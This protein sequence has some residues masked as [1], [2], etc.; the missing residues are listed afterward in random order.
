MNLNASHLLFFLYYSLFITPQIHNYKKK[1]SYEINCGRVRPPSVQLSHIL[2]HFKIDEWHAA[3]KWSKDTK[4][5]TSNP[6]YFSSYRR[7]S[8][9]CPSLFP[10]QHLLRSTSNYLLLHW[11]HCKVPDLSEEESSQEDLGGR[12]ILCGVAWLDK[13]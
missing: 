5:D 4:K 8:L 2:S 9:L 13:G 10:L 7:S 3:H 12:A 11:A 6:I 1:K